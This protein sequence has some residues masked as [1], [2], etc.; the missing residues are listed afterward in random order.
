MTPQESGKVPP[1][2]LVDKLRTLIDEL[3]KALNEQQKAKVEEEKPK[4]LWIELLREFRMHQPS[5]EGHAFQ[6]VANYVFD[7]FGQKL[8]CRKDATIRNAGQDYLRWQEGWND[9]LAEIRQRIEKE[10]FDA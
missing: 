7:W 4:R 6:E 9:C 5:G 8:P 2:K 3:D 1:Y 10:K